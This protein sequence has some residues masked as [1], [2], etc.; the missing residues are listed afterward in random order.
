MSPDRRSRPY[1]SAT[2]IR[3][4][5][6]LEYTMS[7]ESERGEVPPENRPTQAPTSNDAPDIPTALLPPARRVG[8]LEQLRFY[9][10]LFIAPARQALVLI[11]SYVLPSEEGGNPHAVFVRDIRE[12]L[13]LCH[14]QYL[15]T[16]QMSAYSPDACRDFLFPFDRFP[17]LSAAMAV[18]GTA[19]AKLAA[20]AETWPLPDLYSLQPWEMHVRVP[21]LAVGLV[22]ECEAAVNGFEAVL[23]QCEHKI[24][25][26]PAPVPAQP[27][28]TGPT[29]PPSPI[30]FIPG[31]FV[32][33]GEKHDLIGRSRSLLEALL[34]ERYGRLAATDLPGVIGIDVDAVSYPEQVI[35]DA[36]K[37]LRAALR[38]AVQAVGLSCDDPLPSGGKG[39]DLYYRLALP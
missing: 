36:A 7:T 38:R 35:R 25:S 12:K 13:R 23:D 1:S 5:P 34:N 16:V 11:R 2:P 26:C 22:S 9:R 39:K 29:A 33:R 30:E 10:S 19:L 15:E 32:Y 3:T 8:M 4:L 20:E 37:D 27:A 24:N 31:G 18:Y 17:L 28:T 21:R 6:E 14:S